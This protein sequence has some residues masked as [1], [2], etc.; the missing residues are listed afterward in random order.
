MQNMTEGKKIA[1]HFFATLSFRSIP[2]LSEGVEHRGPTSFQDL[3]PLPKGKRVLVTRSERAWCLVEKEC[4]EKVINFPTP[5]T[6]ATKGCQN[7]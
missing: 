4:R 7:N 2:P 1:F 3:A 6:L 5:S